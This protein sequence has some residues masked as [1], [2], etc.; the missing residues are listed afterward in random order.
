MEP[1]Q[2]QLFQSLQK[3]GDYSRCPSPNHLETY[4]V[5]HVCRKV[6]TRGPFSSAL[7]HGH[8]ARERTL[9]SAA[10]KS[11]GAE[12]PSTHHARHHHTGGSGS[13]AEQSRGTPVTWWPPPA[14]QNLVLSIIFLGHRGRGP[15]QRKRNG[16]FNSL[17]LW[18]VLVSSGDGETQRST[19]S[20]H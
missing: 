10:P 11:R 6:R 7:A 20:P 12:I 18:P 1:E 15:W 4:S 8:R 3:D 19:R 13:G 2:R 17:L 9:S 5:Q 16:G 14:R